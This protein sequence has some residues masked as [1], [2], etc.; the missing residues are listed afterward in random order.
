MQKTESA[1]MGVI[2]AGGLSRRMGG[3]D[4]GLSF[5]DGRTIL[6]RIAARLRPQVAALFLNANGDARRFKAL[7][8]SILPDGVPDFPGPLAGVLAGLDHAAQA[9]FDEV[10]VVPCDA[11]FLPADLVTR[12]RAGTQAGR[13]AVAVSAGRRHPTAALWPVHLRTALRKALVEEDQRRVETFLR[14][15][16]FAEVVWPA[17]PFDP[18]ANVNDPGGMAEAEALLAH[19]PAA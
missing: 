16:D 15:H 10:A 18:F 12:L 7:G 4:K 17:E 2:L 11:P 6:E 14:R 13:G 8:L 19:F 3:G 9:G 5:L 1:V